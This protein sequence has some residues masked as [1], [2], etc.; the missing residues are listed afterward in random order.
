[1][2]NGKCNNPPLSWKE[3]GETLCVMNISQRRG[4]K[5]GERGKRR[6]DDKLTI[7]K[8]REKIKKGEI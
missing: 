1:V 7:A 6:L 5:K 4:G 8:K 2:D 3:T